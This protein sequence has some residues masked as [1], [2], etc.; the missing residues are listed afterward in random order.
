MNHMQHTPNKLQRL[1][2]RI[3]DKIEKMKAEHYKN[4]S[5][6]KE[7]IDGFGSTWL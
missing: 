7:Q 3:E 4:K 1:E 6:H 5:L 2:A